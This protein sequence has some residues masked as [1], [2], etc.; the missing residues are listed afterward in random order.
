MVCNPPMGLCTNTVHVCKEGSGGA[1]R[2][3]IKTTCHPRGYS[4]QKLKTRYT[5]K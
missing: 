1:T 3:T 4:A 5:I 2:N